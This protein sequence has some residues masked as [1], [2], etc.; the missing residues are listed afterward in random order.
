MAERVLERLQHEL[1]KDRVKLVQQE[2]IIKVL[3]SKDARVKS[4]LAQVKVQFAALKEDEAAIIALLYSVLISNGAST[5]MQ[6]FSNQFI[7][8]CSGAEY[9]II[10]LTRSSDG[11]KP[12]RYRQEK[13]QRVLKTNALPES[14]K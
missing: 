4:S 13:R 1:D 9:G 10:S 3:H 11:G 8:K 12:L 5:I 7:A 6:D 14:R 2:D